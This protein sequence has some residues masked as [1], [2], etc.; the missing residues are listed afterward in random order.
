MTKGFNSKIGC[1]NKRDKNDKNVSRV[2]DISKCR[3][4]EKYLKKYGYQ[5][6]NKG[7][8][9]KITLTVNPTVQLSNDVK[10][11]DDLRKEDP[12]PVGPLFGPPIT[13]ESDEKYPLI[14]PLRVGDEIKVWGSFEDEI[15]DRFSINIMGPEDPLQ[16]DYFLVH[17][18]FR[19]AG[20]YPLVINNK[21]P[22]YPYWGLEVHPKIGSQFFKK[23]KTFDFTIKVLEN[24]YKLSLN[25]RELS[26]RFPQRD[27]I[28]DAKYLM[29]SGSAAVQLS[30]DVIDD[31]RKEDPVPDMLNVGSPFGPPITWESVEKYP[32]I[33][34][35][36]VGDEIKVWG[37]FEDETTDKFSINIMGPED[38]LQDDYVLVHVEF[39]PVGFYPIVIN[40]KSPRYPNWGPE[41]NPVLLR[42]FFEKQ[43]TFDFKIEVL[44]NEYK[45][46]LN[47][48]ELSERFPQR[49]DIADAG[50]LMLVG[51]AATNGIQWGTIELTAAMP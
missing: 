5:C 40:N 44:E 9:V 23:Q 14:N 28:A 3:A 22:R 16:D 49:D 32:L 4:S 8:K 24:E 18:S 11:K 19:P 45:L 34:P 10:L 21:S 30:N 47:G 38:P 6:K 29:L 13:W 25:G 37:S 41:V 20:F 42:H 46:S 31:I 12:V 2:K 17:V 33:N 51:S 35:L 27:D 43:T 39:R 36:R 15:T 48:R 26:E 7:G 1:R 50:Y